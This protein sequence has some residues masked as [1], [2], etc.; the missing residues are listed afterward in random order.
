MEMQ[1]LEI[2]IDGEGA[3]RI[4]V[5]GVQGEACAV[6]T[7]SLEEAIGEVR[8]RTVT[9]EFYEKP[10]TEVQMANRNRRQSG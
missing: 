2:I 10:V 9:S 3:V 5:R 7:Q 4:G 6:L 8:E 1:E